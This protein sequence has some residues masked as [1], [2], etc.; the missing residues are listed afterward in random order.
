MVGLASVMKAACSDE[1]G[2]SGRCLR[3]SRTAAKTETKRAKRGAGDRKL[4]AV[5]FAWM[6]LLGGHLRVMMYYLADYQ[7]SL[8]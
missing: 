5:I 8:V 6:W 7:C 2:E 3:E 1:E 4:G